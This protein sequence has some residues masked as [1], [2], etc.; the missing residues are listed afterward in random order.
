MRGGSMPRTR[1]AAALLMAASAILNAAC[2]DDGPATGPNAA[3]DLPQL[4]PEQAVSPDPL[5]AHAR[6]IPGF[7]GFFLDP[8]GRPTVYL[9]D[10][11]HRRA[12]E[13]ALAQTLR[14]LGK[15]EAELRVVKAD[16]DYLQLHAWFTQ[17]APEALAVPG[18]VFA[19]LDEGSNRLRLGV[20]TGAAENQVRGMLARLGIPREAVLVERIEP[21]HELATLRNVVTPRRGGLQV[22]FGSR[23]CSLGFNATTS[24]G[25][26]VVRAFITN[27]H[28]TRVRGGVEGTTYHQPV[29]PNFIGTE[30]SDPAY[31]RGGL[32]PRLRRCRFSDAARVRYASGV[33]SDLGGIA[34]TTYRA[35]SFGSS[36]ING[37][38]PFFNI[39]AE[40]S[41][42]QGAT[43]NKVGS[44]TGWTY[45]TINGT[46][47]NMNVSGT[48][49]TLLCQSKTNVGA[50]GKVGPGDSGSPVFYWSG[51]NNV[52]LVGL[53]W[54]GSAWGTFFAFS[55]MSGIEQE[56]G[57]LRTF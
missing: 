56:L 28:C 22:A 48:D 13:T 54:G 26:V 42:I 39:T 7:G 49:I 34:R 15:A 24:R 2:H 4:R 37:L 18:T 45:G 41:P 6:A 46:C 53:L 1:T 20:E 5:L 16:Y 38:N 32:C 3:P 40:A 44:M 12:A 21:V 31:F 57:T 14:G 27:S 30:V 11:G 36:I 55:P 50:I 8:N 52:G 29:A 43:V 17:A 19:D 25:G 9:K 35:S 33:S 47:V 10:A 51:G 23:L